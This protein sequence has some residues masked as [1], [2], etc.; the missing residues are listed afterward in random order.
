M[1]DLIKTNFFGGK[2]VTFFAF[3]T[4]FRESTNSEN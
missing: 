1:K 4:S 3:C 2:N